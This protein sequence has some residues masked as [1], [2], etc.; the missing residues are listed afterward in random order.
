MIEN[1]ANLC[2]LMVLLDEKKVSSSSLNEEFFNFFPAV[3][4]GSFLSFQ[5]INQ[6][7]LSEGSLQI[8]YTLF[9][10]IH[11]YIDYSTILFLSKKY[12]ILCLY[13]LPYKKENQFQSKH[14]FFHSIYKLNLFLIYDLL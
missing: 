10:L 4:K 1:Q 2:L 5:K 9:Q 3:Q 6:I 8:F 13:L 11:E 12:L 14:L 7:I